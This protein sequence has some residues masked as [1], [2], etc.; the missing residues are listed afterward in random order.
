TPDDLSDLA[1]KAVRSCCNAKKD[2]FNE[3]YGELAKLGNAPFHDTKTYFR[4][5]R[6]KID[7]PPLN[8]LPDNFKNR[9]REALTTIEQTAGKLARMEFD[10]TQARQLKQEL[11]DWIATLNDMS[12]NLEYVHLTQQGPAFDQARDIRNAFQSEIGN[13]IEKVVAKIEFL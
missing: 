7:Q 13:Q 4:D 12:L 1:E 10:P 2:R 3:Q 11:H 8:G 6:T 5:M 9:A